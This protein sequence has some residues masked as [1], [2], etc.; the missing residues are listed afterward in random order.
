VLDDAGRP[1][2]DVTVRGSGPPGGALEVT[3]DARG[4]AL[5]RHLPPGSYRLSVEHELLGHIRHLV[6]LSLPEGE[7][8][9]RFAG[10][11]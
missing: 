5:A 4:E 10:A 2:P 6:D 9:L 1:V 7:V 3:T 8:V 11:R